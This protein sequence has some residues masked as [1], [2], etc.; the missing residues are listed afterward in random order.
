MFID[1]QQAWM[2]EDVFDEYLQIRIKVAE[3]SIQEHFEK[4]NTAKIEEL[5]G[6]LA[7]ATGSWRSQ[8][9]RI[10]GV[11]FFKFM[12]P[13]EIGSNGLVISIWLRIGSLK[14]ALR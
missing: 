3:Q 10:W 1:L 9:R 6:K 8:L 11:F 14:M 12:G 2:V 4:E 13:K 5:K 7:K